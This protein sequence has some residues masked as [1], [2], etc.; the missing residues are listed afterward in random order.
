MEYVSP[1]SFDTCKHI[2]FIVL[3]HSRQTKICNLRLQF[4]IQQNVVSFNISMGK[5]LRTSR[6]EECESLR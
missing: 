2:P 4:V 3:A 5:A 6:M 1:L